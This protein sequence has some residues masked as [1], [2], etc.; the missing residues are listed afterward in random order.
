MQKNI[1]VVWRSIGWN[2]LQTKFQALSHKI[3][4]QRPFEIAVTIPA[5]ERN[6]RSDGA[7]FVQNRFGAHIPKMPDFM[8]I[9]GHRFH[10]F[11]QTIVCIGEN[12]NA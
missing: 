8:C 9:F 10:V 1:N 6:A 4:H 3:D 12:E 5:H 7:Q 11:R 2:V